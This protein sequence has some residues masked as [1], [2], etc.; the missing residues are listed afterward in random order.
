MKSIPSS[1]LTT[2]FTSPR[3]GSIRSA[4]TRF[5]SGTSTTAVL[6]SLPTGR[7]F[8]RI[9]WC[10]TRTI[11]TRRSRGDSA[12]ARTLHDARQ[13]LGNTREHRGIRGAG[14]LATVDEPDDQVRVTQRGE[15]L[16]G[17]LRTANEA[18]RYS[19]HFHRELLG[20][21]PSPDVA[22]HV[23]DQPALGM[24]VVRHQQRD[25]NPYAP[26]RAGAD[27]HIEIGNFSTFP[28]AFEYVTGLAAHRRAAVHPTVHERRAG[29]T[30]RAR[31]GITKEIFGCLI[32]GPNLALKVYSKSRVSCALQEF[33]Q[34][35]L[36]H[37]SHP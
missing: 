31:S 22:H 37:N 7:N 23:D 14:A 24:L 21:L 3:L 6:S 29:I 13:P 9:A 2:P 28:N 27:L 18:P 26:P 17:L 16:A 5:S 10:L 20:L 33:G 32:P 11:M 8:R 36:Q 15:H 25:V 19:E 34:L 1:S 12:G 30:N 4:A 35:S